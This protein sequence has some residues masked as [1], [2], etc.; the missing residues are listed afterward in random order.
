MKKLAILIPTCNEEIH[1]SRCLSNLKDYQN[2]YIL[3]T[4]SSDKTIEIATSYKAKI[5]SSQKKF[6]SFSEK[7]NFGLNFLYEEFNWVFV[8]HADE[9]ITPSIKIL[10]NRIFNNE[11]NKYDVISIKRKLS[12][13]GKILNY[14]G[15][16]TNQIRFFKSKKAYYK[17]S[18]IDEKVYVKGEVLKTSCQIIDLPLNNFSVW[19]DK[20]SVYSINQSRKIKK[21]KMNN[22]SENG[23]VQ[24]LY[25]KSPLFVRCFILFF[26][27]YIFLLG[28]LDG[29][30]GLAYG[31]SHNIIYRLMVDVRIITGDM[32][33]QDNIKHKIL[34]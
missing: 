10:S 5:I 14:G 18:P 31:V 22:V 23:F 30:S 27:K 13:L 32:K 6:S 19:L 24:D 20:H 34:E 28:F 21:Q 29:K 12:F 16:T 26:Y 2:I 15:N 3:D 9:I 7:L 25:E 4:D 1:I 11:L 17:E 8:L 33:Y